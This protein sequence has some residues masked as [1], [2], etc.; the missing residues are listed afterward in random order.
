MQN[1]KINLKLSVRTAHFVCVNKE[2]RSG[3]NI[4]F[5]IHP[6]DHH[7][8][9]AVYHREGVSITPIFIAR[10]HNDARY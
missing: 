8:S 3:N 6:D 10:Q 9:D 4:S 7:S 1:T 5:Y 2:H